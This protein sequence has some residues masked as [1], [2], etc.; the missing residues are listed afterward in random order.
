MP[1]GSQTCYNAGPYQLHVVH[2]T[3]SSLSAG[4]TTASADQ[5]TLHQHQHQ[6]HHHRHRQQQHQ[7]LATAAA[8]VIKYKALTVT[9][10]FSSYIH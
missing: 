5:T 8:A 7:Q 10:Q 3:S 2:H 1:Q 6:Y 4:N 9:G